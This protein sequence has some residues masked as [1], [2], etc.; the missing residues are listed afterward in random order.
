MKAWILEGFG[1]MDKLR[2]ADMAA[3]VPAEGESVV[4][5]RAAGVNPVD[6]STIAGRFDWIRAP[7]VTGAEFA[8]VLSESGGDAAGLRPGTRVLVSPKL[9]CG[10]CHY[11]L[12]GEESACL[13]NE[14]ISSAPHILGVSRQG[15]WREK[16]DVPDR[17][18]VPIPDGVSFRDAC[19]I[20]VDG[21]TAWRLVKRGRPKL[22]ELAVV[23]GAAGGVG[24]FAVQIARLHG[25]EV[26]AVV[27]NDSQA[28]KMR[29]LGAD[30]V[31]NRNAV[32][33]P[34]AV[35]SIS[36]GR[37]ADIVI[38][39]LGSATFDASSASLAPLGRYVTCGTLTGAKSELSLLHLY[40]MQVEYVGSTT[41]SRADI[42]DALSATAS[43]KLKPQIDA[44]FPFEQLPAAMRRLDEH[45]RFGKVL[46]ELG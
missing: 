26:A 3:P 22:N 11:C 16:A 18:L 4:D 9:F 28:E 27:G 24:S 44:V 29:G 34:K 17:N 38:D 46:V 2:F 13:T 35:K 32:D 37:G 41:F 43:G 10:R 1:G 14:H 33:V 30:H 6:R 45:G 40:S 5:V 23:M 25:C 15:G 39:P 12:R 7:F 31:I 36:D 42:S 20:G 21:A 19:T 8:G